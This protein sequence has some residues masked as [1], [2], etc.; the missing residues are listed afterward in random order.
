M[1]VCGRKNVSRGR[2]DR[3]SCVFDGIKYTVYLGINTTHTT[4]KFCLLGC[5]AVMTSRSSLTSQYTSTNLYGVTFQNMI[6]RSIQPLPQKLQNIK[7][8]MRR[9]VIFPWFWLIIISPASYFGGSSF[10]SRSRTLRFFAVLHSPSK[11]VH[12]QPRNLSGLPDKRSGGTLM[13]G[14][15]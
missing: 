15:R 3:S 8:H 9:D 4:L 14:N 5:V 2:D 1:A 13:M 6:S 10:D 7:W 12:G 11:Q